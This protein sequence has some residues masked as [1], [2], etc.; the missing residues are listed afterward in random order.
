MMDY[1][2]SCLCKG[3][4][5]MIKTFSFDR[6]PSSIY[7]LTHWSTFCALLNQTQGSL[8]AIHGFKL[9]QS[10]H[11]VDMFLVRGSLDS[12]GLAVI[13][14]LSLH[15]GLLLWSFHPPGDSWHI[16]G[17]HAFVLLVLSRCNVGGLDGRHDC[18]HQVLCGL[19]KGHCTVQLH[20]RDR[21][22][23]IRN[24]QPF[25]LLYIFFFF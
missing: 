17:L 3:R 23:S 16:E 20:W 22:E 2:K 7:I 10:L 1:Q 11:G 4:T 15:Q 9:A 25:I 21:R 12:V 13:L 14:L 19:N 18:I 24:G 8:D 6:M 5:N